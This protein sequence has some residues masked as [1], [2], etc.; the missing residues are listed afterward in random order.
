MT[1]QS[2]VQ[3]I[4][5]L[6]DEVQMTPSRTPERIRSILAAIETVLT[7][8]GL[9]LYQ[10]G[11]HQRFLSIICRRAAEL[12]EDVCRNGLAGYGTF[13]FWSKLASELLRA[14]DQYRLQASRM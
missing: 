1:T 14:N 10:G 6:L 3:K 7:G 2:I 9:M 5:M 11:E 8:D 4:H 12:A 13:M